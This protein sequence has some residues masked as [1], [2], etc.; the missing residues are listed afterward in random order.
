[1]VATEP[2][3]EPVLKRTYSSTSTTHFSILVCMGLGNLGH[4]PHPGRMRWVARHHSS[5]NLA[6]IPQGRQPQFGNRNPRQIWCMFLA[7]LTEAESAHSVPHGILV[8][9]D[10]IALKRASTRTSASAA[11]RGLSSA[12]MAN[13]IAVVV[14]SNVSSVARFVQLSQMSSRERMLSSWSVTLPNS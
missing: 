8:V 9:R 6:L 2:L 5:L 13:S 3:F 14:C 4:P 7:S 10:E 12:S 1:M 11:A